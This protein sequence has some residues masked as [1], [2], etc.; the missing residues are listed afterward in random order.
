MAAQRQSMNE[1]L[2]P[3][4]TEIDIKEVEFIG[5]VG[6]G[7]FGT[8]IKGTWM[9]NYVAVKYITQES[10]RNAFITE[11]KQLSRVAH[12]NIIGLY[13]AC[14]K[15]PD[16]CLV[17]EYADGGSLHTALHCR[18][19]P[20]YTAAHAMSWARQCAEGVAYLHDM[21][22][23]AMI[24][25]DLKPP[26][27]LLV[28]DG[29]V[30]KICDFGTVTDK[31]TRMTNNK[32]SAA[33]M[34]P[35]VFEGSTYTEKCDVFSWGIILW[36]VIAREQPFRNIENSYAIMWRVH[37]GS[38]PRLIDDCPKPI[39]QLMINCWNQNPADRPSMQQVVDTMNQLCKFFTGE[40]E[41]IIY[42]DDPDDDEDESYQCEE[43]TLDT[44]RHGSTSSYKSTYYGKDH[45]TVTSKNTNHTD[46]N[47]SIAA[48]IRSNVVYR[49]P[50][51]DAYSIGTDYGRYQIKN[52]VTPSG[53]YTKSARPGTGGGYGSPDFGFRNT[54]VRRVRPKS[55]PPQVANSAATSHLHGPLTV[56]IDP[57]MTWK[58]VDTEGSFHDLVDSASNNQ[59]TE[60]LVVTR[61]NNGP[62]DGGLPCAPA[63]SAGAL[64]SGK[65]S[66][67]S[68][69]NTSHIT[70]TSSTTTTTGSSN[71]N[72]SAAA[73]D[74]VSS[75]TSK[76]FSTSA[77]EAALDYKSLNSILDD[78]LRPLTPLP[79]NPRSEQIHNE[80]K[81][82]VKEYWEIQTQ[83]VTNQAHR[84]TLQMNMPADE[85]R[86]KKEYLK[87]LEEKEALLKFKANLQKQLDER[88]RIASGSN[89][90][91]AAGPA[92]LQQAQHQQSAPPPSFFPSSSSSSSSGPAVS[93][94][95]GLRRQDSTTE[96]GWVIIS[97]EDGATGN[98][99]S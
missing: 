56:D 42:P 23:K 26:N 81:Q 77:A 19:K 31:S 66:S 8:V 48:A 37:Q 78:N 12:P 36:E 13:G 22:P 32:G 60:R 95:A 85:L 4:V 68:N 25:R 28:R 99:P 29:T 67:T 51:R 73:G 93:S 3:F 63:T 34:A 98:S 18:P 27:L 74:A 89:L 57:S 14:T 70:S 58:T 7:T 52:N 64:A 72:N 97:P 11:V 47:T 83:I 17:M 15:R 88:K 62:I 24:H 20:I 30:L 35:E 69:L 5:T 65:L 55:P 49:V 84:D 43:N 91:H 71:I 10:E 46:T 50:T 21:T 1:I 87:K 75:S 59:G 44:N 40:N 96:S 38:R 33:W 86:L 39:S 82:L 45:S 80:H 76:T 79:G 16:V 90:L 54:A 6:K 92:H 41:P 53:L 94:P 9:G 2:P 61:R